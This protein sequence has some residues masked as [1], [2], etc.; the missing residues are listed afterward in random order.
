MQLN[1]TYACVYRYIDIFSFLSPLDFD[2]DDSASVS[3]DEGQRSAASSPTPSSSS[4][5]SKRKKKQPKTG[6]MLRVQEL[7]AEAR[8]GKKEKGLEKEEGKRGS[9]RLKVLN[10][11]ILFFIINNTSLSLS[12]SLSLSLL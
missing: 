6:G 3:T 7:K 12:F 5:S 2:D 8:R 9:K 4:S 11:F 10:Y 1:W